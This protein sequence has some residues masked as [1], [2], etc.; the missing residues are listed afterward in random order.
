MSTAFV[1]TKYWTLFTKW[2]HR[3]FSLSGYSNHL[4][5][6]IFYSNIRIFTHLLYTHTHTQHVYM[7]DVHFRV[8]WNSLATGDDKIVFVIQNISGSSPQTC[9]EKLHASYIVWCSL[10]KGIVNNSKG[11]AQLCT[12]C[13]DQPAISRLVKRAMTFLLPVSKSKFNAW[14]LIQVR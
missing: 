9:Q 14:V 7:Q 10:S 12:T 13:S 2:L 1:N 11:T 3:I 5:Y 8:Y 4:E 6:L